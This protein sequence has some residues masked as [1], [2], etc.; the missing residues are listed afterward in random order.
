MKS[1]LVNLLVVL[2]LI[3]CSFN[4]YQWFREAKLHGQIQ[5]LG[6]EIFK[7]S[8]EIQNLQQTVQI[9]QEEIKRLENIRENFN[10]LVKSNRLVISALEEQSEKY[11]RDAQVQAAKAAQVE[12]YKTAYEKANE[13]IVKANEVIQ[14]QNERMKGLA[15]E[16][17]QFVERSN[18]LT[19]DYKSL[20]E[21]YQKVLGLYT[22][23]VAQVNAANE[24][25][26][27]R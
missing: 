7:K 14:Q 16:R 8:G 26:A 6:G 20:A 25:N 2:S 4:A 18:K 15:E 19:L 23:L 9:H 17:N 13:G 11:R 24:K 27:R 3:L 1:F 5:T 12:Q 21:D 22:N 10:T